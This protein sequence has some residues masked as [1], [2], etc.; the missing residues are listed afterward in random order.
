MPYNAILLRS[1]IHNLFDDYQFSVW[2]CGFYLC[3]FLEKA[4]LPAR[5]NMA[6]RTVTTTSI[7]LKRV[8]LP[9]CRIISK[10]FL[11]DRPLKQISLPDMLLSLVPMMSLGISSMFISGRRCCGMYLAKDG[12]HPPM[13][14]SPLK[15]TGRTSI[16]LT[17]AFSRH[18]HCTLRRASMMLR[19]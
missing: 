12:L 11:R 9:A 13:R 8:V 14:F 18:I 7:V 17:T 1:D 3:A 15:L 16:W 5:R 10:F 4:I 6:V 2:V 19:S